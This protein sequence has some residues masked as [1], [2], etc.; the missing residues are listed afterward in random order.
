LQISVLFRVIKEINGTRRYATGYLSVTK[1][2][3]ADRVS[4]AK[5]IDA[6]L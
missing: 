1:F 2:L 4:T 6:Y 3:A 5:F